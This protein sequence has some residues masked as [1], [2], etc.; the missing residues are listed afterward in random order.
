[1]TRGSKVAPAEVESLS[2]SGGRRQGH[3]PLLCCCPG[4]GALYLRS[5]ATRLLICTNSSVSLARDP[6]GSPEGHQVRRNVASL[7]GMG[8]PSPGFLRL[9]RE[10]GWKG[11]GNS[12]CRATGS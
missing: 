5:V 4:N 7:E 12:S 8:S 10:L 9:R 6:A 3:A 2:L 11:F 1:V